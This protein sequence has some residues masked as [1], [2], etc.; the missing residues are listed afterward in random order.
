MFITNEACSSPILNA[1]AGDGESHWTSVEVSIQKIWFLM[2]LRVV[3]RSDI[4]PFEYA[5]TFLMSN[6]DQVAHFLALD[7]PDLIVE[8]A[9]IVTPDHVNG[10]QG[11]AMDELIRVWNYQADPAKR[12][13]F[14]YEA[15]SGKRYSD[16]SLTTSVNKSK[17]LTLEF[18]LPS[19]NHD[20]I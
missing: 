7:T 11:W 4:E 2:S 5:R 8:A 20:R 1:L 10:S 13:V 6:F 15:I 14:V 9:Y 19:A 16:S 3:D 17:L 18:E 12:R